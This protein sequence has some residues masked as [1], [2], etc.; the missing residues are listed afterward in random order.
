[1]SD[2]LAAE[3]QP[4]FSTK[5][6]EASQAATGVIGSP[7]VRPSYP[8]AALK[9]IPGLEGPKDL[10]VE[11]WREYDFADY[12]GRT[13]TYR[14]MNPVAFY[15]RLGGTTHRVVDQFGV[16]HCVPAPGCNGCVLR[17]KNRDT[18]DPVSY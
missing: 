12:E 15:Y 7:L 6:Q 16:V 2:H 17:W 14:I 13:R 10:T 3:K 1:M 5:E 11:V 4:Q 8:T 18:S 9:R